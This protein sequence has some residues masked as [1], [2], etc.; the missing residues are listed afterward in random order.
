MHGSDSNTGIEEE[1]ARRGSQIETEVN[2][3]LITKKS[4]W[5]G[6]FPHRWLLMLL[7]L[8]LLLVLLLYQ[9]YLN[10]HNVHHGDSQKGNTCKT[11]QNEHPQCTEGDTINLNTSVVSATLD[12]MTGVVVDGVD[13]VSEILSTGVDKGSEILLLAIHNTIGLSSLTPA[14]TRAFLGVT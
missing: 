2:C 8:L 9:K 12:N 13:K 11:P 6:L 4:P 1:I 14:Y 10:S 3:T 5:T 7:M